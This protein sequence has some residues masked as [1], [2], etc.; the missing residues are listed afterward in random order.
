MNW[1]SFV[2]KKNAKTFVLPEG[3]DSRDKVAE[4]LECSPDKVDDHLRPALKSGEILKQQ[5]KVWDGNLK[6]IVFVT[7]YK[8][9]KAEEAADAPSIPFDPEKAKALK[10]QGKSWREIGAVFG[11]SGEAVRSRLRFAA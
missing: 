11:I 3:W 10:K 2:E 1:K 5:F 4:Q 8:E 7:A 6:R 9:A